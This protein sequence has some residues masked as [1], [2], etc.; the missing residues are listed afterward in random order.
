[1]H[2]DPAAAAPA[3]DAAD[4]PIELVL[5]LLGEP[6]DDEQ[7]GHC[8]LT[9]LVR[10]SAVE[11]MTEAIEATAAK[12]RKRVPDLQVTVIA[13]DYTIKGADGEPTDPQ[14]C[15]THRM[16][17]C[18]EDGNPWA[19]VP[20][21][22]IVTP[23][24][25]VE[26]YADGLPM[27]DGGWY[28]V[29]ILTRDEVGVVSRHSVADRFEGIVGANV[30]RMGECDHCGHNRSRNTT[31][32]VG[33]DDTDEVRAIGKSCIAEY[34]GNALRPDALSTLTELGD[35]FAQA[36]GVAATEAPMCAPTVDVVALSII[37]GRR[38]GF[39]PVSKA[40]YRKNPA[41]AWRISD[42]MLYD[43]KGKRP[44]MLVSEVTDADR[45]AASEALA[46]MLD[47]SGDDD[48]DRG[49]EYLANLRAAAAVEWTQIEGRRN[50]VGILASLPGAR[51]RRA[52][53]L[54]R[55]A[56]R[57]A[58]QADVVNAWIGEPKQRRPFTGTVVRRAGFEGDYGWMDILV[59]DTAEGQIIAKGTVGSCDLYERGDAITLTATIH[60]ENPHVLDEYQGR[61]MRQT[62]VQRVKITSQAPVRNA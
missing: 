37:A 29:G 47:E 24:S 26:V 48:A 59:V 58:A 2:T 34:T 53:A 55:R 31:V 57:E 52:A 39:V 5:D 44:E 7:A 12:L 14:F 1:M 38:W 21:H 60:P 51:E 56:A 18:Y 46:L 40:D 50:K 4:M 43:G 62:R 45:A 19:V 16:I 20:C 13:H 27:F 30:E 25:W 42:A 54:A 10:R 28:V 36:S 11:P 41:T 8:V 15:L 17:G 23:A 49:N 22:K 3:L 33:N 6:A 32:L 9:Q 35:R 61:S